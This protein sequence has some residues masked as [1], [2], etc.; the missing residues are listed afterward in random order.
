MKKLIFIL[1]IFFTSILVTNATPCKVISGDGTNIGDEIQCGTEN[2]YVLSNDGKEIK[3]LAKYNLYT[4][5]EFDIHYFDVPV[6]NC[7]Q[8]YN[9]WFDEKTSEFRMEKCLYNDDNYVYGVLQYKELV[10][11]EIKQNEKALGAHGGSK[12]EPEFPEIGVHKSI[13]DEYENEKDFGNM[14]SY[15]NDGYMDFGVNYLNDLTKYNDYLTKLGMIDNSISILSVSELDKLIYEI[16]NK[17]LPLVEWWESEWEDSSENGDSIHSNYMIVGSIS[18]YIP[19]E[20]SWI[21]STTY[22]TR[23]MIGEEIYPDIYFVDTLGNLCLTEY[24]CNEAIGAGIRPVVTIPAYL[25]Y[26]IETKTDG[27]GTVEA[28]HVEAEN[29]TEV[30]FTVT[31]KEG[32]V[33]SEVKVTDSNGNVVI[34]T[35]YT[36]TMP[37]ANVLIE[38]TFIPISDKENPN[39]SDIFA[40]VCTIFVISGIL[41]T[42]SNRKRIKLN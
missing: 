2:F 22:W 23:T 9:L 15:G 31:P 20:Y 42:Y 40:I 16:S 12:G 39:T 30:K 1:S 14:D 24:A 13:Y 33:L 18:E 34:F 5:Y 27:N 21:Y 7:V 17:H 4:G 26:Q 29:G 37:N 41:L 35:D 28:D 32:Y 8:A 3:M 11:E 25:V 36:F 19:D 10:Y 38:A 6:Q